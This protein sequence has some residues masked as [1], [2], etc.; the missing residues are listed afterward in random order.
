MV[1]TYLS[2]PS[3]GTWSNMPSRRAERRTQSSY[4]RRV[5]SAATSQTFE[6]MAANTIVT[7][8]LRQCPGQY[9]PSQA[10]IPVIIA[11]Q[12][13][14]RIT[15]ARLSHNSVARLTLVSAMTAW[16]SNVSKLSALRQYFQSIDLS[17]LFAIT[18]YKECLNM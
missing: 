2:Q 10:I 8:T 1:A 5:T 18:I 17:S 13:F 15:V 14:V 7:L 11:V 9:R 4:E 12:R 3:A 6:W 16:S